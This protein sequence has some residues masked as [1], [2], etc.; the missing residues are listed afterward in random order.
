M[1]VVGKREAGRQIGS[2]D[3][4][5]AFYQ[6]ETVTLTAGA[7]ETTKF[8]SHVESITLTG[9]TGTSTITFEPDTQKTVVQFQATDPQFPGYTGVI[10]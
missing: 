3:R 4:L 9:I 8:F 6:E 10:A 7:G 5:S 2:D 1:K